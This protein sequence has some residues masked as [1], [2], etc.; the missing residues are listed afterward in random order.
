MCWSRKRFS[1]RSG[2]SPSAKDTV[3][4]GDD[5][6]IRLVPVIYVRFGRRRGRL[7]AHGRQ[8]CI[9]QPVDICIQRIIAVNGIDMTLH[10]RLEESLLLAFRRHRNQTYCAANSA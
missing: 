4:V 2:F 3:T 10:L 8:Q 9:S 6:R 1:V 7:Q 5:D